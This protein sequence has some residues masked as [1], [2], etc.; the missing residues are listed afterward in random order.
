MGALPRARQGWAGGLVVLMRM[1]GIVVGARVA[2]FAYE[3]R[4]ALH[5]AGDLDAAAV[6]FRDTFVV[7]AGIGAVAVLLSLVPPRRP[8]A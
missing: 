1:L 8:A 6:A 3:G 5:R 4:L 2:T 7:A